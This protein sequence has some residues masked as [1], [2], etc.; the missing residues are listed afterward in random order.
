MNKF[1]QKYGPWVLV[2]GASSGI[3]EEYARQFAARKLHI[4]LVARRKDRLEKLADELT[5]AYK[6]ETKI[7]VADLLAKEGLKTIMDKTSKLEIGLLVNNA[8]TEDSGH[9][10]ETPVDKALDV[11]SL[12]CKAPLVLTHHF[13]KKMAKRKRGGILFMSSLV[14]F[15]GVPYVA[16]Y[17]A[18]KAYVLTLAESLAAELQPHHI[19]VLSVNPGFAKTEFSSE[20]NFDG[21]PL[22]PLSAKKVA[23]A[24]INALSKK[25]VIVPGIINKFIY[26]TGKYIQTRKLNSFIFGK[27]FSHI[28][29]KKL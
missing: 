5:A 23:A 26:I 17:A 28:L 12:N 24:G 10:L 14:A 8:G 15:Q 7:I 4:V 13:A 21:M 27:V 6:I 19:D 18:T 22:K 25:R 29:R 11:F 2:T 3:G 1:N 9:F 16:N 20:F